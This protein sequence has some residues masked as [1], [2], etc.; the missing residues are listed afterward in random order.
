MKMFSTYSVKIKHYNHIFKDTVS[1]YRDA[2]DFFID[3]CIG[4]W[5]YISTVGGN[6]RQQQYVERLC[7][8]TKD[9]SSP[10]YAAFDRKFY[11]LPSYLRRGAI[12]EAIGKVSSYQSNLANWTTADMKTRGRQPAYPK[13]GYIYPCLYRGNMYQQ[14]DICEARIKVFVRN[15]WDWITV[16]LHKSDVVYIARHCVSRKQC[17]PTLQKRGKEWFLDFPF[18][19]DVT[20]GEKD[21]YQQTILAVDLGINSPAVVS[22]MTACILAAKEHLPRAASAIRPKRSEG[23][24]QESQ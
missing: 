4:E 17:A 23:P 8:A 24:V 1:I 15:T 10:K 3:V 16:Q 21:I 13:A 6:L 18:E 12:N 22:V 19:E 11:K 14:T 9:N 2:V 5:E 20:L 7:H